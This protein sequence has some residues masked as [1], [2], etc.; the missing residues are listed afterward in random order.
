MGIVA[1]TEYMEFT[2]IWKR[3]NLLRHALIMQRRPHPR[4]Y[5]TPHYADGAERREG[6]GGKA[7]QFVARFDAEIAQLR[8]PPPM[9]SRQKKSTAVAPAEA[10]RPLKESP[11]I[12]APS[13]LFVVRPSAPHPRRRCDRMQ[14]KE[15]FL[16]SQVDR[17]VRCHEDEAL[18]VLA[19]KKAAI[20]RSVSKKKHGEQDE[21]SSDLLHARHF[22]IEE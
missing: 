14:R 4:R 3:R 19:R 10:T 1:A 7:L 6:G 15:A 17:L 21:E 12:R 16:I 13:A 2:V 8:P 9:P 18:I 11:S 5:S 22:P 20:A